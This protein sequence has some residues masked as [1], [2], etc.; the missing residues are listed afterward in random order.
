MV[1]AAPWYVAD[2]RQAREKVAGKSAHSRKK[3]QK[4]S[5]CEIAKEAT[6]I[7]LFNPAET[8]GSYGFLFDS[9]IARRLPTQKIPWNKTEISRANFRPDVRNLRLIALYENRAFLRNFNFN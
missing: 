9:I 7:V 2:E 5:T 1:T 4:D 6:T 3:Q 8:S